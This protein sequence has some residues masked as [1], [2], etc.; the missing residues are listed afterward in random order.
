MRC[1]GD[2][3]KF[4]LKKLWSSTHMTLVFFCGAATFVTGLCG[5]RGVWAAQKA[6]KKKIVCFIGIFLYETMTM[7]LKP[8]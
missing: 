2:S 8:K 4:I 1:D 7:K 5:G 6:G 3:V